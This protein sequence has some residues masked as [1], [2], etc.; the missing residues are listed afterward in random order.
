M[1]EDFEMGWNSKRIA[2]VA[3]WQDCKCSSIKR[4]RCHLEESLWQHCPALGFR[5]GSWLFGAQG[6][7]GVVPIESQRFSP[8][9]EVY[10]IRVWAVNEVRHAMTGFSLS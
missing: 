3:L 10:I 7:A 8:G 1:T 4:T 2:A 9:S 5:M 6:V